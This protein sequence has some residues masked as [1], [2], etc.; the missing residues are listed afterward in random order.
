MEYPVTGI[1][2]SSTCP[3]SIPDVTITQ[4][5]NILSTTTHG[6]AYQWYLNGAPIVGQTN[7]SLEVVDNFSGVYQLLVYFDYGCQFSNNIA[8]LNE[9]SLDLKI[10][11]NPAREFIEINGSKTNFNT[12]HMLNLQGK[13]VKSG[14]LNFSKTKIELQDLSTGTYLLEI[15]GTQKAHYKVLIQR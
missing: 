12:F 7:D 5:N 14:T 3:N 8:Q 10:Y 6:S 9:F 13:I 15:C 4:N 11:P 1:A 2:L